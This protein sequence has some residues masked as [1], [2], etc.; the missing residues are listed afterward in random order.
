M[1][2]CSILNDEYS[3]STSKFLS[4]QHTIDRLHAHNISF[5]IG[6]GSDAVCNG[7]GPMVLNTFATALFVVDQLMQAAASGIEH[8]YFHSWGYLTETFSVLVYGNRAAPDRFLAQPIYYG[9]VMFAQATRD[10]ARVVQLNVSSSSNSRVHA[11]A[12]YDTR[13]AL[14]VVVVHK[15]LAATA[16]ARVSFSIPYAG[17]ETVQG[18]LSRLLAPSITSEYNVT[19]AGQT[20]DGSVD[21]FPIGTQTLEQ[22]VGTPTGSGALQFAFSVQPL[23]AALLQIQLVQPPKPEQL[24]AVQTD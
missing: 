2:V 21:G 15:D 4:E 8:W 9:L 17:N 19:L 22:V 13:G 12:T 1:C 5:V 16:P 18:E 20:Y 6:E 10:Y 3:S 24:E 11:Y 14:K 23:S 7:Q